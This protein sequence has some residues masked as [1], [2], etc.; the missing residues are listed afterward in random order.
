MD[1]FSDVAFFM[2]IN[3]LGSLAAA[4]Q[5]LGVTPSAV[6][7]RLI[8]LESRLGVR[9][10]NRTT[11]RI[12]LTPEGENYLVEGARILAELET[13]ERSVGGN[14]G[15]PQGLVRIGATLGFGRRHIAPALAA[16]SRAFPKIEIQLYLSE[17]PLNLTELGLDAVVHFG[18]LP[19]VRLTARLLA[20]NRRVLCAAPSY[21]ARA[22]LPASPR[23]LARHSCIF[24]READ[25][26]FGT[27][28]MR[29]GSQHETVKV[30]GTMST[31]DGESAVAWAL[32][33]QGLVVRSEWD[34]AEPLRSGALCRVLPQWQFAPADIYLVYRGSKTRPDKVGVLVDFLLAHFANHRQAKPGSDGRW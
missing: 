20:N 19:D 14:S 7:K 28:H 27:W 16:F 6:S 18:E 22:G 30:R 15:T 1:G 23:D 11:R 29:N 5:E 17:R 25:E 34:V 8:A 9:L 31:N 33:G 24:I 2:A 13:L 4:A 3:K 10:L 12:S 26:T 32:E 21:L